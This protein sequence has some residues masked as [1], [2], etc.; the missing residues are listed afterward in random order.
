MLRLKVINHNNDF[1][2]L[3]PHFELLTYFVNICFYIWMLRLSS[4]ITP[5][6]QNA[7]DILRSLDIT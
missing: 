1:Q 2:G 4:K 6:E 3:I 5:I 7:D